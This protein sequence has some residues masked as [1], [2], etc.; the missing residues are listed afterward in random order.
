MFHGIWILR[1]TTHSSA[2]DCPVG[3]GVASLRLKYPHAPEVGGYSQPS[4]LQSG[5]TNKPMPFPACMTK[6]SVVH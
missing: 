6:A 2:Q 3:V 4:I 5:S 1:P